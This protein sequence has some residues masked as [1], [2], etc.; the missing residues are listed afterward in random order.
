MYFLISTKNLLLLVVLLWFKCE[1]KK[2]KNSG[3]SRS[4]F[5]I[6]VIFIKNK[7]ELWSKDF[8]FYNQCC[9]IRHCCLYM[10]NLINIITYCS[11]GQ[12]GMSRCLILETLVEISY[13]LN[14]LDN[15]FLSL[16]AFWNQKTK[17]DYMIFP[18]QCCFMYKIMYKII[19]ESQKEGN[20]HD[21]PC[22]YIDSV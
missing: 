21:Y 7:R 13:F 6:N 4:L 18:F 8:S 5:D 9:C 3:Y 2:S 16:F 20:S 19:I 15:R 22:I 1:R 10:C 12:R 17:I 14:F 11:N